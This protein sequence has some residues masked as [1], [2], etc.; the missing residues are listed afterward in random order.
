MAVGELKPFDAIRYTTSYGENCVAT[1]K[2][3]VVTIQGDKNGVRKMPLDE[4]MQAFIKDQQKVNLE[5]TPQQDTVSFSGN[6][7]IQ[8]QKLGSAG[9]GPG[10]P[11][12][13]EKSK[14]GLWATLALI[15]VGVGLYGLTKGKAGG[16]AF[17]VLAD[18][19][20]KK[21]G[22]AVAG[23]ADDVAQKGYKI[24]ANATKHFENL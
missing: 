7:N 11:K 9:Y 12:Y 10:H 16:K 14:K 6:K 24:V 20:V 17:T 23:V 3:R 4:F 15:F 22:K 8:E 5:R 2:D 18:D 1:K 13:E 21:G 19:V